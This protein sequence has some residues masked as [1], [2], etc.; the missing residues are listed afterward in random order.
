MQNDKND[1]TVQDPVTV[2]ETAVEHSL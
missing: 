2:G 1:F